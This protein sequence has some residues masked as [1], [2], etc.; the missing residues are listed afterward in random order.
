M[1][2]SGFGR[3]GSAAMAYVFPGELSEFGATAWAP[4]NQRETRHSILSIAENPQARSPLRI[5]R[6]ASLPATVENGFADFRTFIR[7]LVGLPIESANVCRY[8]AF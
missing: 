3:P 1:M 2:Q 5:C 6:C 4:S 8:I 7:S